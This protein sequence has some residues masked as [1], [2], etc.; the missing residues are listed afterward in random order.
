MAKI[1]DLKKAYDGEWL[2]VVVTKRE[3][4]QSV[5][6]DLVFHS[7]DQHDV[8]KHV[9]GDKRTLY[10]TYAGPPLPPGWAAAVSMW[11]PAR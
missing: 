5:E 10:V 7:K 11:I 3:D 2:A 1:A 9:K 6:G 4:H 8:W